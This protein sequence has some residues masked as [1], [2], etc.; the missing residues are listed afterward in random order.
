MQTLSGAGLAIIGHHR[1]LKPILIQGLERGNH[2]AFDLGRLAAMFIN[3]IFYRV[4]IGPV[5]VKRDHLLRQHG[6]PFGAHLGK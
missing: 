1:Q 4:T 3:D 2:I 6:L 5:M